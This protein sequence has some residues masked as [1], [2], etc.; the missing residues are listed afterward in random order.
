MQLKFEEDL[1]PNP[2]SLD[3]PTAVKSKLANKSL[4]QNQVKLRQMIVLYISSYD[5][6]R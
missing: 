5:W 4:W 2:E 3:A 6:R 1:E